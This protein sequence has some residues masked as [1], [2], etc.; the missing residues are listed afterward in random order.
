[1]DMNFG[2]GNDSFFEQGNRSTDK[3]EV[4][5]VSKTGSNEIGRGSGKIDEEKELPKE[6]CAPIT[7][8]LLL[9]KMMHSENFEIHDFQISGI[10]VFGKITNVKELASAIIFEI[11][12]YTGTIEAKYNKDAKNDKIKNHIENLKVND[13]VKIVGGVYSPESKTEQVQISISYINK[14]DDWVSYFS[15]F[16][17]DIIYCY[18]KLLKLKNMNLSNGINNQEKPWSHINLDSYYNQMDEVD[19]DIIKY[20]HTTNEKYANQEDIFNNLRKYHSEI[21]IK[22]SLTKLIEQYDLAQYEDIISIP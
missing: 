13:H 18:L 22:K 6:L 5:E 10:I 7:I 2:F 4:E 8:K 9:N 20:L 21:N 3:E 11:C 17:S 15:Y 14:V 12:D 1:M 19:S 16:T